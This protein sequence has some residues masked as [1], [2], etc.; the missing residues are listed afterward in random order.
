MNSA[1]AIPLISQQIRH[2]A[3]L[4][5]RSVFDEWAVIALDRSSVA[6]ILFYEGHRADTFTKDL[7]DDS[8]AL[9]EATAART[10]EIGDF[11]FVHHAAAARIDAFLRLGPSAYLLC[12]ATTRTMEEIRSDPRWLKAQVAWFEL[13]QAFRADPLEFVGGMSAQPF[14]KAP[15]VSK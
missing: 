7:P 12:N 10:C 3:T 1:E 15:K 9:R 5:G 4:Y 11:E 8:R 13:G 14:A 2:M 6:S